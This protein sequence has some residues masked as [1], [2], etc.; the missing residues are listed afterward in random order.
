MQEINSTIVNREWQLTHLSSAFEMLKQENPESEV[1]LSCTAFLVW[2]KKGKKAK[3]REGEGR[4]EIVV[5]VEGSVP[6]VKVKTADYWIVSFHHKEVKN[7]EVFP[8]DFVLKI[9]SKDFLA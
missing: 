8:C 7:K 2:K 1:N 6:R 3:R 4:K 5:R 9:I